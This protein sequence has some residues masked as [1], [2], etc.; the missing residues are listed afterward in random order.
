M[1]RGSNEQE[2]CTARELIFSDVF[3]S[4][5]QRFLKLEISSSILLLGTTTLALVWA[6]SVFAPTYTHFWHSKL[7]ICLGQHCHSHSILHWVND[8]LM[9]FFFFL[10]GLEIK[11][12]VL[13]GELSVLRVALLPVVAAVGGMAVPGIIYALFNHGSA[14]MSGWAIPMATDIAFALGALALLGRGLP[15]G[16]RIFLAA[17]AIADDLGAVLIIALFYTS[18]VNT[19]ALGLA[20]IVLAAMAMV[21]FF[22]VSS[23]AP[24]ALLG[25]FLW[26]AVLYSGVHPTVAGVAAAMMI[27]ARGKVDFEF[28]FSQ[29]KRILHRVQGPKIQLC[30]W[31]SILMDP[32]YQDTVQDMKLACEKV[33][34]PLQRIEH[35]IHPWVAFVILPIFALGNAGLVLV[36]LPVVESLTNPVTMGIALGLFVGKPLG[37]MLFAGVAV[38]MGLA[39]L[40]EGVEWKDMLGVAILGGIGFTMS[41]FVSGLSFVSPD[42]ITASKLGVLAGSGLSAVFGLVVLQVVRRTRRS[43]DP[44]LAGEPGAEAGAGREPERAAEQGDRKQS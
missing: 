8:G 25:F 12:E 15:V 10:V 28:F 37:V 33:E 29:V 32:D 31:Y 2:F 38:W 21:N 14:A 35:S 19:L 20:G 3:V 30:S 42:M 27:P 39:T 40:P 5:M 18:D 34:T 4:P 13:V 11:R 1:P 9:A 6:N 36:G 7:S 23:T 26:L 44:C 41:L 16:L 43:P 22:R 24:Y 17:F